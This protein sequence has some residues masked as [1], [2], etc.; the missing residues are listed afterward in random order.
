MTTSS[1]LQIIMTDKD[2]RQIANNMF[3]GYAK[4]QL[5]SKLFCKCIKIDFKL[6]TK[7]KWDVA[8][9]DNTW[10]II[11]KYCIPRGVRIDSYADDSSQS[12]I[13]MKLVLAST[14]DINL[15]D[16]DM[17]YIKKVE[18]SYSKV[19]KDIQLQKQELLMEQTQDPRFIQHPPCGI[20]IC[21][22]FQYLPLTNLF[23]FGSPIQCLFLAK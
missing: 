3:Q 20:Y 21:N 11:K 4:Q 10:S 12:K 9:H 1:T 18:N 8:I 6:W 17:H 7:E 14:Y 2:Y 15:E 19:L 22:K 16:W 23:L 5:E 13:L